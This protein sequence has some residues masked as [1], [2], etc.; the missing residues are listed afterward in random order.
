MLSNLSLNARRALALDH[1]R[2][3]LAIRQ[4]AEASGLKLPETIADS[5]FWEER[6]PKESP[7]LVTAARGGCN[8]RKFFLSVLRTV[9]A[10]KCAHQTDN[11][12]PKFKPTFDKSGVEELSQNR[13]GGDKQVTTGPH[14][15]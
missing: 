6:L 15:S 3:W 7:R 9:A 10:S 11:L 5:H 13:T 2:K 12:S 4:T 14:C 8:I 1:V